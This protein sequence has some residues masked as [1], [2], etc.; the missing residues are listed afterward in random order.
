M[1]PE[2]FV[3]NIAELARPLSILILCTGLMAAVFIRTA[4]F[5]IASLVATVAGALVGARSFE[6]HSEIKAKADVAKATG[7]DL[8]TTVK[9]VVTPAAATQTVEKTS[10]PNPPPPPPANQD[11]NRMG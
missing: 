1:T 6:N 4:N 2:R 10:S 8:S 3:S 9:T 11:T 7:T 5:G